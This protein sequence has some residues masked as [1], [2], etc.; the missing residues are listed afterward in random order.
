MYEGDVITTDR[1]SRVSLLYQ[2]EELIQIPEETTLKITAEKLSLPEQEKSVRLKHVLSAAYVGLKSSLFPP[3]V[4]SSPGAARKWL[5][6]T[7]AEV[8]DLVTPAATKV[9]TAY[10]QFEWVSLE[11]ARRYELTVL[12]GLGRIVWKYQTTEP[13]INYPQ[14]APALVSGDYYFWQ[15]KPWMAMRRRATDGKIYYA[16]V[17]LTYFIVM[18]EEEVAEIQRTVAEAK[19]IAGT[20]P[21]ETLTV[22]VAV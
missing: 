2:D 11:G 12:D 10:P 8:I 14:N 18:P 4:L 5:R 22:L 19:Q 3:P 21:D 9:M 7:E 20:P 13:K 6:L 15:V 17:G 16:T 1:L